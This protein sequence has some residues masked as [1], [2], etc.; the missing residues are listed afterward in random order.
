LRTRFPTDRKPYT[1]DYDYDA[2]SDLEEEDWG[3][4]DVDGPRVVAGKGKSDKSDTSTPVGGQDPD[5]KG[6][7]SLDIIS[8]SD[9]DSLF[10]DS[11]DTKIEAGV[12]ATPTPTHAGTVVV[13][14]DVGF[15][16]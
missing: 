2:D 1:G 3:S 13:I 12:A 9:M 6:N 8:V 4:S 7:K 16:T 14:E 15:V 5:G 10:S 11:P